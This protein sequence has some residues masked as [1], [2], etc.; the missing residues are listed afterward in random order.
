M[1]NVPVSSTRSLRCI[2]AEMILFEKAHSREDWKNHIVNYLTG[3]IREFYKGRLA[4][5]NNLSPQD[6]EHWYK[7]TRGLID[8][9]LAAYDT[10]IK[11]GKNKQKAYKEARAEV[12]LAD[13]ERRRNATRVILKDFKLE[14]LEHNITDEDTEAFWELANVLN[15]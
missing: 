15:A 14:K 11:G 6:V 5:K 9:A 3:A 12:I 4:E 7:E 1:I 13:A 8:G 10:S 2:I